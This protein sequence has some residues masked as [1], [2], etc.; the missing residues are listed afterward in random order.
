MTSRF[1]SESK[2]KKPSESRRSETHGKLCGIASQRSSNTKLLGCCSSKILTAS[3]WRHCIKFK[4]PWSKEARRSRFVGFHKQLQARACSA[5][6]TAQYPR[7][8]QIFILEEFAR[9]AA[10]L[11]SGLRHSV[12]NILA[13]VFDWNRQQFD[14][15]P[16]WA[17]PLQN[18]HRPIFGSANPKKESPS[19][20]HLW[21]TFCHL[22]NIPK[23][24]KYSFTCLRNKKTLRNWGPLAVGQ[25]LRRPLSISG[26][27]YWRGSVITSWETE[28][29]ISPN[30]KTPTKKKSAG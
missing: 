29:A 6:G 28:T 18:R 27:R 19:S 10:G 20:A 1:G 4:R 8:E 3:I 23:K 2:S 9:P 16:T 11:W 22:L 7:E 24:I 14:Q 26:H 21:P 13:S 12:S 5:K 15:N 17:R 25:C 30:A